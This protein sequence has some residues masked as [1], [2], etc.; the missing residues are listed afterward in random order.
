MWICNS[1]LPVLSIVMKYLFPSPHFQLICVLCLR[2]GYCKQ[3]NVGS[4]FHIQSA[5]LCLLIGA[6]SPLTVKGII[7]KSFATVN[8]VVQL[9]LCFSFIPFTF[10]VCLFVLAGWFPFILCLCPLLYRFCEWIVCLVLLCG[11]PA[12]Q[13]GWPLP[14]S[15]CFLAW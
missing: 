13:V 11:C 5:S 2:W 10:F 14:V 7:D 1:H 12:F 15:A 4:C 6:F 9:I 8:F 3:H